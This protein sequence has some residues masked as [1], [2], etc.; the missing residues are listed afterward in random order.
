VCTCQF[1][2]APDR[3]QPI[4]RI[5]RPLST[6]TACGRFSTYRPG[7]I[8]RGRDRIR[9]ER[10]SSGKHVNVLPCSRRSM[11]C[12]RC[13]HSWRSVSLLGRSAHLRGMQSA[14]SAKPCSNGAARTPGAPRHLSKVIQR[15]GYT[16]QAMTD[17]GTSLGPFVPVQS[18]DTLRR[19]PAYLGATPAQVADID[20]VVRRCG[21]GTVRFTLQPVRKNLLRLRE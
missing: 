14:E 2:T 21:R 9:A 10:R 17:D 15:N 6:P 13:P 7:A 16:V 18:A 19:L 5:F 8:L 1:A 11:P 20:C 12:L 3:Q 4:R